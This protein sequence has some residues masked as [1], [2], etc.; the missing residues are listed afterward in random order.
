M[1]PVFDEFKVVACMCQYFSKTED[2]FLQPMNHHDTLKI[3]GR[4]YSSKSI[5]FGL[6]DSLPYF[7]R[8]ESE[9]NLFGC[10]FR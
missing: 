3:I 2:Q 1:Q 8:I 4:G 10:L 9:E 6:R 5:M 7:T